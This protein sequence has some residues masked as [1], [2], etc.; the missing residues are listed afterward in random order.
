MTL[1]H[2]PFY[3]EENIWHLCAEFGHQPDAQVAVISNQRQAVAFR[4]QRA[5][6][7]GDGLVV[8]DYHVILLARTESGHWQVWDLDCRRGHPLQVAEYIEASWPEDARQ[9]AATRPMFRVLPASQYQR[10]LRSD[11]S[12]MRDHQGNWLQPPPSWPQL[13]S[14][15]NLGQFVG[16]GQGGPGEVLEMETFR[17]RFAAA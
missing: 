6:R 10:E 4:E 14:H 11:R 9:S 8:W 16:M 5:G 17:A 15:S 13:A 1:L 2:C 3:C 12:H 7:E